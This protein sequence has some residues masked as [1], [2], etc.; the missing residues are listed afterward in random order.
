M[1]ET[2]FAVIYDGPAVASSR[3][4]VTDLAPALLALADVFRDANAVLN[5][6]SPPVSLQIQATDTGSFDVGLVL[7]HEGLIDQIT[8]FFSSD[9]STAL[10]NLKEYVIGGGTGLFFLIRWLKGRRAAQERRNDGSVVYRTADGDSLVIP[11]EVDRLYRNVRIRRRIR[12]VIQPLTRNGIEVVKFRTAET[13]IELEVAE[14]DVESFDVPTEVEEALFDTR[15]TMAVSIAAPAFVED[16][17]WRLS[18]GER[19]FFASI[20][21]KNFL[22]RVDDGEPFR[23]GDILEAEMH[24][25]QTRTETGLH[26][27]WTVERVV[28][29]IPR[30]RPIEIPLFTE[31]DDS[32]NG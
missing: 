22:Q 28:Q 31:E 2:D 16:N 3:M 18:D 12:E 1:A 17:K 14:D 8:T 29:H 13:E 9:P 10:L 24:I 32:P 21:D 4:E 7:A 26:T 19:T 27:D 5:P 25:T 15:M 11:Q 23:K 6:D 20:E 30:A